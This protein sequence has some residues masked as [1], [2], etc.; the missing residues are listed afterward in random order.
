MR[1]T[2]ALFRIQSR[3]L[4][5]RMIICP[6][7]QAVAVVLLAGQAFAA[8]AAPAGRPNIIVILSDDM[9]YS[10]IGCYGGEIETPVLDGL[11][12]NGLRYTQFYNTARCC[13]TRASLLTGLYPHQA[14]IGHMMSDSGHDGYRGDL[15]RRCLTIAEVLQQAGYGTY[16]AGK[17]HVTKSVKPDG[18][19][20]NWP[21]QRG[22]DRFYGTIHG[23]GSF[24]DPN[25]LTR[26]NVQ[27]SP[28]ADPEYQPETYYYTDAISDHA[29]RY[30]REHVQDNSDQ[31]FFVYVAYTAAH[32]PMHAL[33]QDIEKYKGRY[34]AGYPAIR[35]SRLAKMKQLGL[36]PPDIAMSAQAE[37]WSRVDHVDWELRCMEVYA[38][39]VDRMDQGIG[40]IVGTL[41]DT[42]QYDNTL[43]LFMQDN[44]GCAEGLGRRASKGRETRPAAPEAPMAKDELQF[45][46]VPK[47]SR[48]GW[49]VIQGPGV[50]PGP[51][52]TYIAYGRGWANVS[53]T[54]FR[55]Y[56]HWVHEGGIST[57]LIAHWPAGI[58]RRGE[59]ETQPGHLVDIMATCVDVA[60]ANYPAT[61]NGEDITPLEGL[62]LAPTFDGQDLSRKALYWEHEGNCAIRVDEWKLV[63]KDNGPWEL[64][65]VVADRSEQTNLA[66]AE[67]TRVRILSALWDDYARRAHVYPLTPWRSK[68]A[69]LSKK[70][71]FVFDG[72]ARVLREQAPMIQDRP[73]R[74]QIEIAKAGTR[75]VLLSQGGTAAGYA[76]YLQDGALHFAARSHGRLFH[77]QGSAPTSGTLRCD[78]SEDGSVAILQ[79]G[80][81]LLQG[82][83]PGLLDAMPIDGL[84][85][86]T[87]TGGPVGDYEAE[88]AFDGEIKEVRLTIR[89]TN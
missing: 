65:N 16:M 55:E 88:Y 70:K 67:P 8:E 78:V 43:V 56:K 3:P 61:F 41:R 84:Q 15:N 66:A 45:D 30:I 46:M 22:F 11:A 14:G 82:Q 87:D 29:S 63:R 52:D 28:D 54:P 71:R 34:D 6:L 80:Q 58:A 69:K 36:V 77:F 68:K 1:V 4:S 33:P 74:I 39:M 13:P 51:A 26:D 37:D 59:L 20:H 85:V 19:K 5:H 24:F 64:Y 62:S 38:A 60:G 48:D 18:P 23:A 44:G 21:L 27:V 9:G 57:P 17:W 42:G 12:E 31:P 50:M 53:N 89:G 76:I 40:Q 86:G 25:S 47:K 35:E 10:D 2:P 73:F 75:G 7:M 72:D 49:P 83:L 32:W 81:S 79:S